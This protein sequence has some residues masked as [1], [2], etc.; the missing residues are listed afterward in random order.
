MIRDVPSLEL[1]VGA[2]IGF[3]ILYIFAVTLPDWIQGQ[4]IDEPGNIKLIFFK[5]SELPGGTIS[6]FLAAHK[7]HTGSWL[8][9]D[10]VE[11]SLPPL[12]VHADLGCNSA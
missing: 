4:Y 3:V 11:T 5:V 6:K 2:G 9:L 7:P 12:P 1:G 8:L 10:F